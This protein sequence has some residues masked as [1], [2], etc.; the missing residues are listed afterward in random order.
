MN[1]LLGAALGLAA[2]SNTTALSVW[3]KP[4][5]G[6]LAFNKVAIIATS[7]DAALRR[8]IEDRVAAQLP[9]VRAT[10]SYQLLPVLTNDR[11]ALRGVLGQEGFDGAV[12]VRIASVDREAT[13]VP[14]GAPYY[15]F[16]AWPM[17]D[18]GFVSVDTY[19][20][21]ETSI[22]AI[23]DADLLFAVTS[24]TANP[25][26]VGDLVDETVTTVREQLRKQGLVAPVSRR[27]QA[28]R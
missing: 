28:S 12:V 20:R 7:K 2:C 13:Y 4:G 1:W 15:G 11:E 14:G 8:Q 19:V 23:P 9:Q 26:D 6:P 18:P 17:Y 10:P 21:V 16:G 27:D 24:R 3:K 5:I 25:S 22:Y